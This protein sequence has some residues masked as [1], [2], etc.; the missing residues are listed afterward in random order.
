[1]FVLT[2]S[3]IDSQFDL[4][5]EFK[6]GMVISINYEASF[7]AGSG[8][9][10]GG[11]PLSQGINIFSLEPDCHDG[12]LLADHRLPGDASE[13]PVSD[14]QLPDSTRGP[15]LHVQP[16]VN[17]FAGTGARDPQA[18]HDRPDSLA[19]SGRWAQESAACITQRDQRHELR[20]D[21]LPVMRWFFERLA[22]KAASA[23]RMAGSADR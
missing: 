3:H 21:Q 20:I 8:S 10:M 9:V 1:L 11:L 17:G 2:L 19:E 12:P 23:R 4:Q 16:S 6:A 15:L 5:G 13:C 7:T 18:T 22:R 14:A